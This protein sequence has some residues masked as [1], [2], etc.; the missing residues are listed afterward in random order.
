MGAGTNTHVP[1][2]A[3]DKPYSQSEL[4]SGGDEPE[5]DCGCGAGSGSDCGCGA[6][7]GGEAGSDRES[8]CD[9][10]IGGETERCSSS[11]ITAA[12]AS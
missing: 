5:L 4:D 10:G 3:D 1:A 12:S 8:G 7:G 11:T 2:I 9:A 6:G